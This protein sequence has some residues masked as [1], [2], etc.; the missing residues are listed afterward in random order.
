MHLLISLGFWFIYFLLWISLFIL[1]FIAFRK[2][3]GLDVDKEILEDH[4]EALASIIR[5]QLIG[6]AIMISSLIYFLWTNVDSVIVKWQ[7]D[8]SYFIVNIADIAAFW[9]LGIIIFQATINILAKIIPLHKEIMIDQNASIW[10]I[11]E[12]L[13]I[14]ISL[15]LSFSIYSY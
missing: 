7:I 9:I 14:A 2:F 3:S 15:I 1:N 11:I 6:Q 13:L 5:W 8:I 10:K 4:N 12:W